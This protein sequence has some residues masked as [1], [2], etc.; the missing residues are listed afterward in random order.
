MAV[1]QWGHNWA[2]KTVQIFSDN[3]SVCDVIF[4]LKPKDQQMQIYL[5]EFLYWVCCYNFN[6]VVSKIISKVNDIADFLSRNFSESDA[7]DFFEKQN[8]PPQTKLYFSDSDFT[9]Q[10]D[11]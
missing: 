9:L 7:A 2:G 4:Y 10:A 8:L 3:D 5:R 1:K 11:W 6:P